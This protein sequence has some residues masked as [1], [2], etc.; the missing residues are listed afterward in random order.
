MAAWAS[1]AF[2]PDA[3]AGTAWAEETF[4]VAP[5]ITTA[6]LPNGQEGVAYS[7]QLTATGTGPIVW[8]LNS[9]VPIGW[10]INAA[11]GVVS[12]ASPT[13]GSVTLL[14]RASNG[15]APDA[16]RTF[17]FQIVE[18]DEFQSAPPASRVWRVVSQRTLASER[19]FRR[20]MDGLAW[21][22]LAVGDVTSV[23]LDYADELDDGE[24]IIASDWTMPAAV[25]G[26]AEGVDGAIASTWV[27]VAAIGNHALV[28]TVV[29]DRGNT[30]NR[31]LMVDARLARS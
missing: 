2:A 29:T 25:I 15:T 23:G 1:G 20:R 21:A 30:F 5:V 26:G 9:P 11:T 28:N 12:R 8:S 27:T 17:A 10:S 13:P 16:T 6:S 18:A 22:V 4:A 19:L 3:F 14:V 31:T 7:Q 24:L